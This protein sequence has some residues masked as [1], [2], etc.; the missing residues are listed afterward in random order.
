M[1]TSTASLPLIIDKLEHLPEF[2][3]VEQLER[4]PLPRAVL[5]CPP[6]YFDIVD[7]KNPFMVGQQGKADLPL[8][9][10]QWEAVK[11]A[12]EEAGIEVKIIPPVEGCEDMVFCANP[13]IAGLDQNG[14]RVCVLSHMRHASRRREVPAHAEWFAAHGYRVVSIGDP[15]WLFEG[16]GDALWHPGR[17][18]IWGGYGPRTNR[19]IYPK[20]S[21]AFGA[22]VVMLELKTDLFYHLDT[23]LA[24]VD[25][26]TAVVHPPALTADGMALVRRMFSRVIEADEHEAAAI[27]ACNGA[28]FLGKR[29]VVQRG[30]ERITGMLKRLGIEVAEVETSE[31]IKSG[32]SVFCMKMYLF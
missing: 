12:F 30:A 8:A 26:N 1:P 27:T 19:E 23:C 25:E 29:Y 32:G 18:L 21:E 2:F 14:R 13:V 20:L 16:C 28:S 17:R 10:K 4:M 7:V 3:S 31:F 6:D 11:R 22:P 24:L 15:S 5:M 9:R